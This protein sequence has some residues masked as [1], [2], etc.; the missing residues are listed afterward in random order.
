MG[1]RIFLLIP[2]TFAGV[3]GI[4]GSL[5][6]AFA[7][8]SVL[9][10]FLLYRLGIS[11]KLVFKKRVIDE[12]IHFSLGNYIADFFLV[13]Q[14]SFLPILILNV[15]GA[16]ETAYFYVAFSIVSLLYAIPNSVF[17]SMFIEGSHDE[18]LRRN[19]IKSLVAVG[20]IIIPAGTLI[21]FSGDLFLSL[22][23]EEYS[24]NA[25]EIL[26]LLVLSTFFVIINT[27]FTAVKRVQKDMKPLI[28]INLLL[29]VSTIAFSY[30]FMLRYGLL[31]VGMG[32]IIGQ[33]VTA[34]GVGVIVWKEG[35]N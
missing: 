12:I 20:L 7:V 21:Y 2:L 11:I 8:S 16:E 3:L 35:W 1:F 27:L 10:I 34:V 4:F 24:F 31:G 13:A 23:G 15:I 32:W 28:S 14:M 18:P 29:F 5:G 33:A 22:F 17:M 25:Y 9:G 26:K 19:V 30:F 6:I